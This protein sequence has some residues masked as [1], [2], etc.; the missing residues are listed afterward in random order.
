MTSLV[1]KQ[2]KHERILRLNNIKYDIIVL[3]QP[4][5][6]LGSAQQPPQVSGAPRK[7]VE[8]RASPADG[9]EEKVQAGSTSIVALK[10]VLSMN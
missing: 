4:L 2:P 10:P 8:V 6:I 9:F 5:R 1:L 3:V 7:E